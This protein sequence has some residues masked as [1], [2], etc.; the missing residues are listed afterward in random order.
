VDFQK[1]IDQ[2]EML[3]MLRGTG[4]ERPEA[5]SRLGST[6]RGRLE[7]S[8]AAHLPFA[9]PLRVNKEVV[10]RVL[11]CEAHLVAYLADDRSGTSAAMVKGGMVDRLFA[12]AV[13]GQRFADDPVADALSASDASGDPRLREAWRE[14]G[15]ADRAD[16]RSGLKE[17]VANLQRQWPGLPNS[18]IPRLQ[19]SLRVELCGGEVVLSGR[20]DLAL[21]KAGTERSGAVLL[22][23]KSGKARP[24]DQDDSWWYALL[25]TIRGGVQP[26]LTGNY[27]VSTGTVDLHRVTT[28]DL[29][30]VIRRVSDALNRLG[31]LATGTEPKR[32]AG[33]LCQWCPAYSSCEDGQRHVRTAS[34]TT[35]EWLDDFSDDWGEDQAEDDD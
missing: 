3:H 27:Y 10:R 28:D 18:A 13:T 8:I 16:V 20:L 2:N 6:I 31:G 11:R 23:V 29:E 22:D 14:L 7:E 15:E 32:N 4:L 17:V 26:F 34:A 12:H 19:E 30:R 24:D 5:D 21:G 33:P 1:P 9:A 25:E 35:S